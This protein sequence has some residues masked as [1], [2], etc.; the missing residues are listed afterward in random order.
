MLAIDKGDRM[1][2]RWRRGGRRLA[3]AEAGSL[4][5]VPGTIAGLSGFLNRRG[6]KIRR[7]SAL[8]GPAVLVLTP[9]LAAKFAPGGG[10]AGSG[11]CS[12]QESSFM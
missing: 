11:L 12:E 8:I 1:A 5:D 3:Q 9:S 10:T 4:D 6:T 7:F 2:R